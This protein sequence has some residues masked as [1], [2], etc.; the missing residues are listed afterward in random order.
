MG[1]F[2]DMTGKRFGKLTVIEKGTTK[3]KRIKWI[4]KCDCGKTLEVDGTLLR[5]RQRSCGCARK[6]HIKHGKTHSRLYAIWCDMKQRCLNPNEKT[7]FRYG[8]R[9]ITICDEWRDDFASF[10]RWAMQSGYDKKAPRG[11]CTLDRVDVNGNYCPENCRWTTNKVQCNN[12]RSN[13]YL[14]FNGEKH[15]IAEWSDIMGI[16]QST[17]SVRLSRYGWSVKEA[18]TIPADYRNRVMQKKK[19]I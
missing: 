8:G 10:E 11:Q 4:C 18:L 2:I 15:T 9:G 13:R 6:E 14:E 12:K 1:K 3:N 7:Y 17:I 16:N 5:I 19:N